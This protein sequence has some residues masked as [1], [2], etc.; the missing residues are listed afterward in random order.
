M[1]LVLLKLVA[2]SLQPREV[3]LFPSTGCMV[4]QSF[5]TNQQAAV[6]GVNYNDNSPEPLVER[7]AG[8]DHSTVGRIGTH[9]ILWA[10]LWDLAARLWG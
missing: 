5:A 9:M 4:P 8:A 10:L 6:P 7:V 3:G 2:P 1:R